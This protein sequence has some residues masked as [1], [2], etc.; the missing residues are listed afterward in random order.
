MGRKVCVV[1]GSRAEYGLLY[2][3][4]EEIKSD[5]NL[6]L[7]L[8]ATGMHLSPRFGNTYRVIEEDGFAIDAKVDMELDGDTPL[9]IAESMA[10]GVTG[11]SEAL[12]RL[13]PDIVVVLGDRFE[14]LA[15]AQAAMLAAVPLEIGR[16]SCRERV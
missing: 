10:A 12:V 6:D 2:W 16:A 8:V 1:T 3:L 14:I 9:D 13:K 7:Q 5:P 15:A 4:L 11:M